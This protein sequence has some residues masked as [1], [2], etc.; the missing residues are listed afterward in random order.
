MNKPSAQPDY[1]CDSPEDIQEVRPFYWVLMIVLLA[2]YAWALV[3]S[4]ARRE[5]LRLIPFTILMVVHAGLHWTSP[6][7]TVR[8]RWLIPYLVLQGALVF[9]ITLIAGNQGI[10]IGLYLGLAGEAVGILEDLRL[11]AIAVAAYLVMAA[12]NFALLGGWETVGWFVLVVAPMGL[13]VTVYVMMFNRQAK[14]RDRATRLLRELETAHRQLA[15]YAA[16]AEDLTRAAERQRMARELHDTLAQGLAGLVLQLEALQA[17]LEKGDTHKAG[18]IAG[19]A[20]DRARAALSE[21][22]SAI[23]DLRAQSGSALAETI[24]AEAERFSAATGIPCALQVPP[25]I[26]L[27]E[28]EAEHARRFVSEGLTNVARHARA[29]HASVSLKLRDGLAEIEVCDDGVGLKPSGAVGES[30]HYGLLGLRERARL[31]GGKLDIE[32]APGRGTRL[33]LS[34]LVEAETRNL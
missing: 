21:A 9:V 11:S 3:L 34:L 13:F 7:L 1:F 14:E 6:N 26:K 20:K 33:V 8:R 24:R 25:S 30:G 22:R 15:E 18:L 28:Q 4:P 32:S 31:A 23:D 27:A 19:Q 29:S 17:N 12:L 5:P 10:T 16:Q 2:M